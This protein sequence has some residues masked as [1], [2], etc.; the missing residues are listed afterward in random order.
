MINEK[1]FVAA[2][3]PF[4]NDVS[5]LGALARRVIASVKPDP[6]QLL[7]D[8]LAPLRRLAAANTS[9]DFLRSVLDPMLLT[10]KPIDA[11]LIYRAALTAAKENPDGKA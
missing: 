4:Q 8:E 3:L 1:E 2:W 5:G 10:T 6:S 7:A 11:V 9:D